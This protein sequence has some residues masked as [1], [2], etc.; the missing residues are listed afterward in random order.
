M[1]TLLKVTIA[2]LLLTGVIGFTAISK[3]EAKGGGEPG[4]EPDVVVVEE[5]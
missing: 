3:S 5:M 1:K 4:D 2:T